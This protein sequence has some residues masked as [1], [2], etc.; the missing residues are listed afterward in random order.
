MKKYFL[1]AVIRTTLSMLMKNTNM[2][3]YSTDLP[4]NRPMQPSKSNIT[5]QFSYVKADFLTEVVLLFK[6]EHIAFLSPVVSDILRV[7]FPYPRATFADDIHFSQYTEKFLLSDW[8][9]QL[10]EFNKLPFLHRSTF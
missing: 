5:K 10:L 9:S 2:S 3:W 1:C 6:V 7:S 4:L 8:D